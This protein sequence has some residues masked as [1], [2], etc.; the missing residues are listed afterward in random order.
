MW[1][2]VRGYRKCLFDLIDEVAGHDLYKFSSTKTPKLEL[3]KGKVTGDELRSKPEPGARP[4]PEI[5]SVVPNDDSTAKL[6][7]ERS[8]MSL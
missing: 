4:V 5:L 7:V 2:D 1:L 6:M 8:K 3:K